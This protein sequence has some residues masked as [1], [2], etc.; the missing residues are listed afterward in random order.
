MKSQTAQELGAQRRAMIVP[1]LES[2]GI[3]GT[4]LS[5]INET[6]GLGSNHA[7]SRFMLKMVEVG[8]CYSFRGVVDGEDSATTIFFRTDEAR[9][10]FIRQYRI[11]YVESRR[12][13]HRQQ[14]A[15][16]AEK[17]GRIYKPR[18]HMRERA[19]D[20]SDL[21]RPP[22]AKPTGPASLAGELDL[23]RAK[24]TM[25]PPPPPRWASI[26]TS[27]AGSFSA[28]KIGQYAFEPISCAAKA[29]V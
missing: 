26:D 25:A 28:L 19:A 8:I 23:S 3:A 24:V 16:A 6:L 7:A 2:C 1:L 22:K 10:A 17:A 27:K 9:S 12:A 14:Y 11:D 18:L 20:R 15:S 5:E 4:T 13:K 21:M 29:C